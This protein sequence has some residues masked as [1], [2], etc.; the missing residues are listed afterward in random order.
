[1]LTLVMHIGG[2]QQGKSLTKQ[3]RRRKVDICTGTRSGRDSTRTTERAC[4]HE[5][6]NIAKE[7]IIW[8]RLI[9]DDIEATIV[10]KIFKN[11]FF[12]MALWFPRTRPNLGETR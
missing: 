9:A 10:Q 8:W 11:T 1:M 3:L 2:E 7:Q 12:P 6:T 4:W 5:N